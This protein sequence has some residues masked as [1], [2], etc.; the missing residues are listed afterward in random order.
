MSPFGASGRPGRTLGA[1]RLTL[2]DVAEDS[3]TEL[4]F[5]LDDTDRARGGGLRAGHY[6]IDERNTLTLDGVAFVPG[7]TVSGRLEH[8]GERSQRGRLRVSGGAPR[9]ALLRLRG[10]R[11]RGA[12]GRPPGPRW[13]VR[14]GRHQRPGRATAAS[15][16]DQRPLILPLPHVSSHCQSKTAAPSRAGPSMLLF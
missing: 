8:F 9:A 14:P 3:V 4:I 16:G 12:S 15:K 2:V 7:V 11:V 1:V 5:D 13:A 6:R 10:G